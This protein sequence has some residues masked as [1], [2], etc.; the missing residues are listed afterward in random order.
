MKLY[1][2]RAT[3][4]VGYECPEDGWQDI[5]TRYEDVEFSFD[6]EGLDAKAADLTAGHTQNHDC[7]CTAARANALRAL[8]A[9]HDNHR[10]TYSVVDVSDLLSSI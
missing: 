8:H 3:V 10:Y 6:R 2:L 1:V 7:F 5:C 9:N 4:D